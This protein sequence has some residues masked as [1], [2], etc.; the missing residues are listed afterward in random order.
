MGHHLLG[1][2]P[3]APHGVPVFQALLSMARAHRFATDSEVLLVARQV[4]ERCREEASEHLLS[5][6]VGRGM[7]DRDVLA[8]DTYPDALGAYLARKLHTAVAGPS[9][10]TLP[11]SENTEFKA[12]RSAM[13][14]ILSTPTTT[15]ALIADLAVGI[16]TDPAIEMLLQPVFFHKG[17][18]AI[19]TYRCA[20]TMWLE[21]NRASAL[22]LHSASADLW[23][24]DI[25]PGASL[26]DGIY[27]DH[28]TGVVIGATAVVEDNVEF[29]HGVTLGSTGHKTAPGT[30]RHPTIRSHTTFGCGSTV[31]GDIT[32]GQGA[33]IA[34]QAVVTRNVPSGEPLKQI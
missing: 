29:M 7:A 12:L 25:H 26:G 14:E 11:W 8:Y 27:I 28:A 17:P 2:E 4:W 10:A 6:P 23:G 3:P 22:M 33:T 24:V 15:R 31:L 30:K 1:G 21:G 16:S 20:H 5:S 34:A 18:L 13:T 9:H 19:A 32:V